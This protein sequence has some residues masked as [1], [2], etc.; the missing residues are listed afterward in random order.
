VYSV[1]STTPLLSKGVR[2]K[3][4]EKST[5]PLSPYSSPYS[6]GEETPYSFGEETPYSFGEE[7]PYSFGEETPYSFGEERRLLTPYVYSRREK[8]T[9]PLFPFGNERRG[10][11]QRKEKGE[12]QIQ[13]QRKSNKYEPQ[14][15]SVFLR[16]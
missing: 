3:G 16:K 1:Q 8:S 14:F 11:E 10:E 2:R 15:F 9:I 13:E 6:F 7:T 5:T 12:K 4:R